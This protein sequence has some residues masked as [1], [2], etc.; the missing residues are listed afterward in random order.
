MPTGSKR[1]RA[2]S[3]PRCSRQSPRS[4]WTTQETSCR[5]RRAS[6]ANG[7]R[8]RRRNPRLR[9]FLFRFLRRFLLRWVF[10]HHFSTGPDQDC[11][12]I[13][14]RLLV[15]D[16]N[17]AFLRIEGAADTERGGGLD[18]LIGATNRKLGL[19]FVDP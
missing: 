12:I 1:G 14:T 5:R 15:C 18:R 3:T 13:L 7:V 6:G 17:G 8:A 10:D 16:L 11:S 19:N 4:S 2:K 9:S